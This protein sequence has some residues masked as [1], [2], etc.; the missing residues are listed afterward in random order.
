MSGDHRA[1]ETAATINAEAPVATAL[2]KRAV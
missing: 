2:T 1:A